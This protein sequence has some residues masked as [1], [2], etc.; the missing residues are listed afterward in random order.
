MKWLDNKLYKILLGTASV[1][2][3]V[4]CTDSFLGQDPLSFYE[5]N[6]TYNTESGLD[7]ALAVCD[8]HL[9]YMYT[10]GN[11]NN[12]PIASDYIFSD[13]G[14]YGK[15]D[16][17]ATDL[18]D[19]LAAKIQPTSGLLDNGDGNHIMT[20]WNESFNGVKYANTL[21]AYVDM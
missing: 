1:T 9:R 14:L 18:Q 6:T 10:S 20:L 2:L 11:S 16:A 4:G 19:D 17:N 3:L 13:I 8:R 5:P 15:T 21:L 7:A 12:A